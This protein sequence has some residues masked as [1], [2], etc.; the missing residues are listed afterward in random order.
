MLKQ[1]ILNDYIV[2]SIITLLLYVI[3]VDPSL[4]IDSHFFVALLSEGLAYE[5]RISQIYWF[6]ISPVYKII[7]FIYKDLVAFSFFSTVF[8]ILFSCAIF[9]V[10]SNITSSRKKAYFLVVFLQCYPVIFPYLNFIGLN[11]VAEFFGY[12]YPSHFGFGLGVFTVRD[13]SG[14]AL[15][16]CILFMWRGSYW[17]LLFSALVIIFVHPNNGLSLLILISCFYLYL[18]LSSFNYKYLVFLLVIFSC[19]AV[20]AAI[21]I[22]TDSNFVVDDFSY[23]DWFFGLVKDEIDDFSSVYYFHKFGYLLILYF[24]FAAVA[25]YFSKKYISLAVTVVAPFLI[26]LVFLL[27][28]YFAVNIGVF[29][30]LQ[31]IIPLQ[32]GMK[33]IQLSFIPLVLLSLFLF[34]KVGVYYLFG[35]VLLLL[36][37]VFGARNFD[38]KLRFYKDLFYSENLNYIESLNLL[39]GHNFMIANFR[40]PI[41]ELNSNALI[42]FD[43]YSKTFDLKG[44]LEIDK[45]VKREGY[46]LDY[47]YMENNVSCSSLLDLRDVV[48]NNI[49]AGSSIIFPPYIPMLRDLFY[50]YN[51]FFSDKHDGNLILG[52]RNIGSEITRRMS[53]LLGYT[54]L[55]SSSLSGGL[56]DSQMRYTFLSRNPADFQAISN[57]FKGYNYL[58]TESSVALPFHVVGASKY[59]IIYRINH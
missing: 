16:F 59:F 33:I 6:L 3:V 48:Q 36:A 43:L 13:I 45:L 52:S 26:F 28:E 50:D 32:V 38:D 58:I 14:L 9:F 19:V 24:I 20:F 27:L 17:L 18:F 42:Y 46:I 49:P 54:Y 39:C 53:W 2:V 7:S 21:K 11:Y 47:E 31:F 57:Q 23:S 35:S 25:C 44:V 30:P 22:S 12:I 5:E 34:D 4:P 8:E 1:P 51:V 55:Q 10:G 15:L 41:Y 56:I 29:W 37:L 40:S